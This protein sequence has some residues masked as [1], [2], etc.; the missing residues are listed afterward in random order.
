MHDALT[1]SR[2]LHDEDITVHAT[3]E[4]DLAN[5]RL[6][7]SGRQ[8]LDDTS[9]EVLV[10]D[11]CQI[12]FIDSAGIGACVKLLKMAEGLQRAA[13]VHLCALA[14]VRAF[15]VMGLTKASDVRVA[16]PE[17]PAV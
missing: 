1:I 3:G 10:L 17:T 8:A 13:R 4:M 6:L 5:L 11:L 16:E 15:A 2:Y 7:T 12:T 9:K 14:V